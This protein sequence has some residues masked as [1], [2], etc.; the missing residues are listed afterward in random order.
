MWDFDF[1]RTLGIVVRTWPFVVFRM[2]VYFGITVA[3]ILAT[4]AGAGI[5]YGIG[6]I[7]GDQDGPIT[8]ALWGGFSAS[9][10]SR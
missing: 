1:G 8:F 3:Y 9:A 10:S 4:G 7:F 5:G 6:H 2:V